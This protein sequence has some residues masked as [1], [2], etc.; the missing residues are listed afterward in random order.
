M[1][2]S[3]KEDDEMTPVTYKI[4]FRRNQHARF[5]NREFKINQNWIKQRFRVGKSLK[6]RRTI[7]ALKE[8]TIGKDDVRYDIFDPTSKPKM[9]SKKPKDRCFYP[10]YMKNEKVLTSFK[11]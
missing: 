6:Y 4:P 5:G 2:K 11:E 1:F 7:A 10:Y 8:K 3:S 9:E